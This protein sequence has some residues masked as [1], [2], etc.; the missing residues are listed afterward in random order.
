[1]KRGSFASLAAVQASHA[2]PYRSRFYELSF[3]AP[4]LC[5]TG[6]AVEI[7]RHCSAGSIERSV[8]KAHRAR[9]LGTGDRIS[10]EKPLESRRSPTGCTDCGIPRVELRPRSSHNFL[11]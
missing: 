6:L 2:R 1:M 9:A 11:N 4:E 8:P 5:A 10:P 3:S 7:A